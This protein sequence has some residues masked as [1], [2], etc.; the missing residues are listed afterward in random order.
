MMEGRG[1]HAGQTAVPEI[2]YL[3]PAQLKALRAGHGRLQTKLYP[4]FAH[5]IRN[6]EKSNTCNKCNFHPMP[7]LFLLCYITVFHTVTSF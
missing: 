3:K 4:K 5:K 6:Y 1:L 2:K 7:E